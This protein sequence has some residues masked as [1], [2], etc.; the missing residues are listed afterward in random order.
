MYNDFVF[1]FYFFYL[2]FFFFLQ[3]AAYNIVQIEIWMTGYNHV[4]IA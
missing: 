1:I 2:F 3:N 4:Y